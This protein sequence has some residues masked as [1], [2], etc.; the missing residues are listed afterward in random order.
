MRT[1]QMKRLFIM[2]VVVTT[3]P[4]GVLLALRVTAH[5][6]DPNVEGAPVLMTVKSKEFELI[7][8]MAEAVEYN[9]YIPQRKG[10]WNVNPDNIVQP[11]VIV[12]IG[13]GVSDA[14]DDSIIT[15]YEAFVQGTDLS[16][17]ELKL[18]QG[19][20]YHFFNNIN[21]TLQNIKIGSIQT[22]LGETFRGDITEMV[23]IGFYYRVISH[24]EFPGGVG[25]GS[26]QMRM[27]IL[28]LTGQAGFND[29]VL[30]VNH[31]LSIPR[32][33]G[34]TDSLRSVDPAN[35][36]HQPVTVKHLMSA[37]SSYLYPMFFQGAILEVGLSYA[38]IDI[39][40]IGLEGARLIA[41]RSYTEVTIPDPMYP[42]RF[43]QQME[44]LVFIYETIAWEGV[45]V[46]VDV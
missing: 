4:I 16:E 32:K 14:T 23:E 45:T 34:T 35:L 31:S 27:V 39:V 1:K 7:D 42:E 22:F 37:S 38:G 5:I 6:Q 28:P 33:K 40:P 18:H 11:P 20:R 17:V 24:T 13:R 21:I 2:A 26:G 44:E 10:N 29:V 8:V 3:I 12:K 41:I 46:A 36:V 9:M 15:L 43:Y 25:G 19:V 30:E